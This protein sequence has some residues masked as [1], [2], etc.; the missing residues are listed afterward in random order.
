M[1][2]NFLKVLQNRVDATDVTDKEQP[3]QSEAVQRALEQC[4]QRLIN[5]PASYG[6]SPGSEPRNNRAPTDGTQ[7]GAPA[8]KTGN[9]KPTGAE[10]AA[11]ED[12][13]ANGDVQSDNGGES[14]Q[15][16]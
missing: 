16:E 13:S 14:D 2:D 15:Q 5:N 7:G 3:H 11:D 12:G 9:G 6:D 4:S 1:Y 10:D 8:D